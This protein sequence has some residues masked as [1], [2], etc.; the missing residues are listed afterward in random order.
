MEFGEYQYYLTGVDENSRTGEVTEEVISGTETIR[1]L[2]AVTGLKRGSK[3]DSIGSCR[4]KLTWNKVPGATS[5]IVY[6]SVDGAEYTEVC[7]TESASYLATDGSYGYNNIF[8]SAGHEY[9]FYVVPYWEGPGISN[10]AYGDPSETVLGMELTRI[11]IDEIKNVRKKT[12]ALTWNQYPAC[13]GYEIYYAAKKKAPKD[14]TKAKIKVRRN[15]A[16]VDGLKKGK[17]Y[18]FW[19]RQVQ[20][21]SDGTT[22]KGAWSKAAKIKIKK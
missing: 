14:A 9:R 11:S 12:V 18:Y 7:S 5:Y 15:I 22:Q 19:I 20:K 8:Y 6:R 3:T 10:Y 4:I 17:T 13:T 2:E 1:L 16:R 21:L